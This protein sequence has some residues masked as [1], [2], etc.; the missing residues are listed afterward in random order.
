MIVKKL[1]NETDIF[2]SRSDLLYF[3]FFFFSYAVS[4]GINIV[5]FSIFLANNSIDFSNL[6]NMISFQFIGGVLSVPLTQYISMKFRTVYSLFFGSIIRA[7]GILFLGV[8]A[9]DLLWYLG[10]FFCG[11]GSSMIFTCT[12]YILVLFPESR[13]KEYSVSFIIFIFGA[14][15]YF[16]SFLIEKLQLKIDNLLFIISGLISI[17]SIFILAIIK[18]LYVPIKIYRID[19]SKITRSSYL[20]ILTILYLGYFST[21]LIYFIDKYLVIE[22]YSAMHYMML[23]VI[24]AVFPITI[25]YKKLNNNNLIIIATLLISILVFLLLKFLDYQREL[26]AIYF[27]FGCISVTLFIVSISILKSMVLSHSV[28]Y[29]SSLIITIY[30]IA[31]FAGIVITGQIINIVGEKGL[32]YSMLPISVVYVIFVL[33]NSL[34][35]RGE[36]P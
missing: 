2:L 19:F 30:N 1:I 20:P 3:A 27:I 6:I 31:C 24:F 10:L 35:Y 9:T 26:E 34:I 18:D 12:N 23:G 32:L 15:I 17:V 4:I 25:L 7:I 21:S 22:Q 36:R 16:S 14:A 11:V 5:T 8:G 33:L 13:Y 29:V 28:I